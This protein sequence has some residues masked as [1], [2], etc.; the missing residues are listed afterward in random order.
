M[1]EHREP[2]GDDADGAGEVPPMGRYLARALPLPV[3]AVLGSAVGLCLD[4]W[5]G[6]VFAV[7]TTLVAAVLAAVTAFGVR[8]RLGLAA[9]AAAAVLA[10][11]YHTGPTLHDTYAKKF[12]EVTR[13]AVVDVERTHTSKGGD[14]H[15]C[16]V[17]EV[18]GDE[19]RPDDR[20]APGVR[21]LDEENNCRGQ[22]RLGQDVV[23]FED[24]RGRLAPWLAGSDDRGLD[25][26]RIAWDA[27]LFVIAVGALF[28]ARMVPRPG[29][30]RPPVDL[31]K[32]GDGAGSG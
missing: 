15:V 26:G 9:A 30:R 4:D 27:L 5:V 29:A 32:P 1:G 17:S 10:I 11:G 20:Y 21:R 2:P 31:A 24:P 7:G 8:N 6:L 3:I 14:H 25:T 18:I 28:H 23:L 16:F 19:A 22:F 12:G 13:A